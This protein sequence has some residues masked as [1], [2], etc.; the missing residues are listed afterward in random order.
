MKMRTCLLICICISPGCEFV[1]VFSP[2]LPESRHLGGLPW[3]RVTLETSVLETGWLRAAPPIMGRRANGIWAE[4]HRKFGVCSL[5][6]PWKFSKAFV[7][8]VVSI[9]IFGKIHF[10]VETL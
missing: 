1:F 4:M 5:F 2:W 7:V 8:L 10:N 9:L 3:G 6:G